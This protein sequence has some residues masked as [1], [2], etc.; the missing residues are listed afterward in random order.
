MYAND[1][2]V[3]GVYRIDTFQNYYYY[4]L[5]NSW[6]RIEAIESP[7]RIHNNVSSVNVWKTLSKKGIRSRTSTNI[8][9]II[10]GMR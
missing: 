4:Y 2:Y 1:S 9:G 6:A 8:N 10:R 7:N 3:F 5:I